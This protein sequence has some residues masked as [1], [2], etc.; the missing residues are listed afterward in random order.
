MNAE[1]VIWDALR[2]ALVTRAL[3]LAADLGVARALA[4]GPRSSAELARE[5]GIDADALHRVLRALASDGIFEETVPGVFGNTAASE[6]LARDGWDD[7]AHYQ[8]QFKTLADR[9]ALQRLT[10]DRFERSVLRHLHERFDIGPGEARRG[11]ARP[12]EARRGEAR[13]DTGC[14]AAGP[15]VLPEVDRGAAAV[16]VDDVGVSSSERGHVVHAPEEGVGLAEVA[17]GREAGG[18]RCASAR[19]GDHPAPELDELPLAYTVEVD[20]ASVAA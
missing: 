17:D 6:V 15:V 3:G 10:S 5:R 1:G 19:A 2:G 16:G 20:E 12:G 18:E 11:E 4:A 14:R 7:F 13:R 9:L 8:T